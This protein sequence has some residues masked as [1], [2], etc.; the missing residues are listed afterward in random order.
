MIYGKIS[1]RA[2]HTCTLLSCMLACPSFAIGMT[3]QSYS[4]DYSICIEKSGGV[5]SEMLDCSASELSRQDKKLNAVYKTLMQKATDQKKAALRDS[6][7]GWLS[8]RT[9]SCNLTTIFG[10]G[11]TIDL[12]SASSCELDETTRRTSFLENLIEDQ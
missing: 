8:Y 10:G 9:A 7:R 12:L 5:T 4:K 11:G 1:V 2:V 6:Q 3:F